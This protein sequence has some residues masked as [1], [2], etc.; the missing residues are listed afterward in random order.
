[1]K[2]VKLIYRRRLRYAE[3]YM[4]PVY[5]GRVHIANLLEH[6]D[7]TV[8]V[9]VL[10]GKDI[11]DCRNMEIAKRRLTWSVQHWIRSMGI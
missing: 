5:L 6:P 1:M 2:R 7:K 3:D 4:T 11:K 8:T 9:D 10:Y